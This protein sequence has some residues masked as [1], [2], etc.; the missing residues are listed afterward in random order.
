M[1]PRLRPTRLEY[2]VDGY[3]LRAQ[4][5]AAALSAIGDE[6]EQRRRAIEV[7]KAALFRGRMIAKERLENGA[8]GVETARLICGVTDEVIRALY[9]FITT[10][11]FRSRNPTQGEKIALMA[12]G[13]Y[14]R[15]ALA[16]F[17]DIDLLFVRPYKETAH[18]ESLIEYMLYAL[19]DLGFKV[20]HASRTIEDCLKLSREDMTI[21]TSILEARLLTGDAELGETLRRRFREEVVKG[22]GAEFVAAKLKERDQRHARAGASRFLVEPNVK[23]GKG[24]LRD[25]HTLFWIA[26]YLHPGEGVEAVMRLEMFDRREVRA[27]I[28]AFDFLE[29]VR[30]HLHFVTGRPEERLTFDV[31]PEVARRMG[32]HDR[33]RKDGDNTPAVER[34]MRRYFL[35]AKDVGALTRVFAAKLE[36]EHLKLTPKGLSRFVAAGPTR[37]A[38]SDEGFHLESGRLS[39]DGPGTFD[40]DPVGLLRLFQIA[41]TRDLDLHPDAFTAVTRRLPLITSKVR[42]DPAAARVF[43]D[44]LTRGRKPRRTLELMNESGVLGRFIPEFGRIIA[45]MQFNMYHSYTVDEHTLRAV[46]IINDIA[47]GRIAGELPLA[48]SVAPLIEDREALF[49]AMLLHDTGKGGVGGQEKAGARTARQACERLGLERARIDLVAWLVEHHL[50]MSDFAQKRD[51]ADP[52]TVAAFAAIVQTP[53]RLRLLLVLTVADIRAVGPGVWNG[54]KGQLLRELFAAT[55]TLFRGGRISDAAGVARRRQEAIAYDA[56]MAL[57]SADPDARAWARTMEDAYFAATSPIEQR[58]HLAL[59][60]RAADAGGA[61]A[62]ARVK[63]NRNAAEIVVVAPDRRALFA[64]LALTIARLNGNVVGARIFTSA[65]GEALDIF[66]VQNSSG[67]PFGTDNPRALSRLIEALERAGHGELPPPTPSRDTILARPSPFT[68]APAVAIDNDASQDA[69]VI[70]AS[71]RDRPGLVEALARAI[72]EADLSIQSAH[73]DNYGE[74]AVDAFYVVT[75]DGAKLTDSVGVAALRVQLT[76]LLE[77]ADAPSAAG[78]LQKARASFG[79]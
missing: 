56:R 40:A 59:S 21:R 78:R 54:W 8:G 6:A 12:V 34:F 51:V 20:G 76:K 46:G 61:A 45:Q 28:H 57:T 43:L 3:R 13:G 58:A 55:E 72:S 64:D 71:G 67:Q 42:R 44:I 7:L 17:S 4:L 19:W 38:L 26:Q 22:T 52:S 9:D 25:L 53:E 27:F 73:I 16:P 35:I 14:G 77:A 74:R 79:R 68:F 32:Y 75:A 37:E 69:T 50:V 48:T 10:H 33:P 39:V 62:E 30:A 29:A 41:D 70:E 24:A 1:P 60:R 23:E 15:G 66:H 5:S 49:L 65:D 63:T 47:A 11:V 36:A 31:Q 2:V 18:T